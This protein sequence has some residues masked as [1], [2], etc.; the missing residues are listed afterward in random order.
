NHRIVWTLAPRLRWRVD[1]QRDPDLLPNRESE[2]FGHHADHGTKGA[3]CSNGCADDAGRLRVAIAPEMLAQKDDRFGTRAIV[4]LAKT[5]AENRLDPE[6]GKRRRCDLGSG[7]PLG[8]ALIGGEV[9]RRLRVRA[10][11]LERRLTL[12]PDLQILTADG[13]PRLLLQRIR[14]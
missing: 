13:Q 5:A 3:V 9:H 4:T 8:P 10:E 12:L 7:E 1:R 2:T 14:R 6:C 11:W